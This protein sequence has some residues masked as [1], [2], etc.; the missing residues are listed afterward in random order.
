MGGCDSRLGVSPGYAEQL[1]YFDFYD[2]NGVVLCYVRS[3]CSCPE[4]KTYELTF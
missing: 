4:C 2:R 3:Q 1:P